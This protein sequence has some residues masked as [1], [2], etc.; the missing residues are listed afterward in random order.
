VSCVLKTYEMSLLCFALSL[1]AEEGFDVL[2]FGCINLP[3]ELLLSRA[4]SFDGLLNFVVCRV[5]CNRADEG[6]SGRSDGRGNDRSCLCGGLLG[7]LY[8]ARG[9]WFLSRWQGDVFGSLTDCV[10]LHCHS[11]VTETMVVDCGLGRAL[12][13]LSRCMGD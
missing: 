6:T 11:L 2:V 12:F 10:G 3:V 13:K 7:L 4:F 5:S 1:L 9:G 8:I